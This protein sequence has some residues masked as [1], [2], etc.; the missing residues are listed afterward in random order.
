MS[1]EL[2]RVLNKPVLDLT[3][4]EIGLL[5][6]EQ[7]RWVYAFRTERREIEEAKRNEANAKRRQRYRANRDQVP[8]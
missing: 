8:Y 1:S 4:R 5:T 3:P 2:E 7:Q 6:T